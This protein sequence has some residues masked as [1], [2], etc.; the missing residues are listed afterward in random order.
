MSATDDLN[1]KT[2]GF[3]TVIPILRVSDLDVSLKYYTEVLGFV[4]DWTDDDGNAFASISRDAC[5]LFLSVGDQG[6]SGSWMWISVD[7]TDALHEELLTKGARVRQ[8][9][10]NF[11]WRSREL[12]VEDPDGNVLRLASENT[13]GEPFGDWLDMRGVRWRRESSGRWTRVD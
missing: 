12:Q 11:P 8:P 7:D 4:L 6:N 3:R 5:H 9:P 1:G 2:L 13:P 10:A